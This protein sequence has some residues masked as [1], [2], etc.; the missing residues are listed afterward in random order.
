M[1]YVAPDGGFWEVTLVGKVVHARWGKGSSVKTRTAP[2]NSVAL[3][4]HELAALVKKVSALGYLPEERPTTIADVLRA[5]PEDDSPLIVYGDELLSQ[6]DL[7][8]EVAALVN[9]GKKGELGRFL[10]ANA[11][12]LFGGAENDVHQGHAGDLVWAPGFVKEATL[13]APDT[14]D[15]NEL[16]AVTRR[17]LT[18]P[19]AEFVRELN[20]G[21]SWEN[22][23]DAAMQVTRAKHPELITALRFNAFDPHEFALADIDAGDF[24]EVWARLPEL[25]E[26]RACAGVLEPGELVLPELRT[27]SRLGGF[28]SREVRA[29]T[30]AKWPK[31]ERLEL[32]FGD[33]DPTLLLAWFFTKPQTFTHLALRGLELS[34]E[35]VEGLLDSDLLKQLHTLDLSDVVLDDDAA[36]LLQDGAEEMA[37]LAK[38]ASP[39]FMDELGEPT[40]PVLDD[41]DNL[42]EDAF[43]AG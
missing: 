21:L 31:L 13:F 22:W 30:R 38:I 11:P 36:E 42:V 33:E 4:K 23:G 3:A 32:G 39:W 7:R 35:L 41:L 2:F 27:F 40:T 43:E 20:F 17:F 5:H 1:R 14:S 19:V 29:L 26:F 24:S 8:G 15:A 34:A 6:G 28:T 18:A 25:R 9:R 12:A 37:H 10:L 16:V